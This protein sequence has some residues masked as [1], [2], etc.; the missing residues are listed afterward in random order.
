MTATM[1]IRELIENRLQEV[2][3]EVAHLRDTLKRLDGNDAAPTTRRRPERARQAEPSTAA[4]PAPA[5]TRAR[6]RS[7]PKLRTGGVGSA[8]LQQLLRKTDGLSTV[9]VAERANVGR[10]QALRLLKELEGRGEI[11]RTGQRRAVR[12][13][14]VTDEDRI[15]ERAA[16]LERQKGKSDSR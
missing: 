12:W 4:G 7:K 3:A 15:R 2:E 13:H 14:A 8:Q 9:A 16:E 1:A 5:R 11:R 10:D 6:R